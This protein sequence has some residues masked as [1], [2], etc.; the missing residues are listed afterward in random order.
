MQAYDIMMLVVLGVATLLGFRKG[1][2]WQVAS[3]AAIFVSYLVALRFRDRVAEFISATPPWNTFLAMLLV[4]IASS[5]VIWM[6]FQLVRGVID[7]AKLKEFDHHLGA[8]FGLLKGVV[9]C[10]I[11]TLFAVTLLPEDTR[12]QI[13]G[14]RSG[15]YIARLLDQAHGVMPEEVHE[16]LHPYIYRLDE[17]HG[18]G[19]GIYQTETVADEFQELEAWLEQS[20][21]RVQSELPWGEADVNSNPIRSAIGSR[22]GIGREPTAVPEQGA[23]GSTEAEPQRRLPLF[24][25]R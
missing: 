6:M 22:L 13:I 5:L 23:A 17:N 16:F 14:S 8:V 9:L 19:T 24:R 20:A 21:N 12:H 25:R 2:A 1:L 15:L 7:R 4:Y 3:I 18:T 11:I 10:V